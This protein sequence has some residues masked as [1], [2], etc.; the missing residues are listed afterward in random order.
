MKIT[1]VYFLF[2]FST[3]SRFTRTASFKSEQEHSSYM[4]ATFSFDCQSSI[5]L[6]VFKFNIQWMAFNR[7]LSPSSTSIASSISVT[8]NE[9]WNVHSNA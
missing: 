4:D 9:F 3:C 7:R 1:F 6:I 8:L 5:E 2:A